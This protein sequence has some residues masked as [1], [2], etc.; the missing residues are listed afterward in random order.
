M[1]EEIL[2][3]DFDRLTELTG[4]LK[5]FNYELKQVKSV[6]NE[7]L[8]KH[9]SISSSIGTDE[10]LHRYATERKYVIIMLSICA[11]IEMSNRQKD[12]IRNV[13]YLLAGR[14]GLAVLDAYI[15]HVEEHYKHLIYQ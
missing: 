8:Q 9:G 13:V 2:N 12:A 14:P 1:T 6:D 15:L 4:N 10:V 7:I 5:F 11:Y 3:F